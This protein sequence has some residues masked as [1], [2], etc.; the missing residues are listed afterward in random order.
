VSLIKETTLYMH[1]ELNITAV[2][3]ILISDAT[4]ICVLNRGFREKS[5]YFCANTTLEH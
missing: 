1:A 2:V 5:A 4:V 3:K